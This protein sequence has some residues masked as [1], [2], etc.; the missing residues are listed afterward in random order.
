MGTA[1]RVLKL[2]VPRG[3][4]ASVRVNLRTSMILSIGRISMANI[5]VLQCKSYSRSI[6]FT[7]IR[8]RIQQYLGAYQHQLNSNADWCTQTYEQ[9]LC[10]F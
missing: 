6:L 8:S 7:K 10:G 2:P 4:L 3:R 9:S 5:G 1:E